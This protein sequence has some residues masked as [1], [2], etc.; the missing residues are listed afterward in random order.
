[1]RYIKVVIGSIVFSLSQISCEST[2]STTER[3]LELT[4]NG[5][6]QPYS[7]SCIDRACC[8]FSEDGVELFCDKDSNN[9][10]QKCNSLDKKCNPEGLPC[11][12]NGGMKTDCVNVAFGDDNEPIYLCL[13]QN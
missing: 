9:T 8:R 12:L 6:Y 3:L 10:C 7:Q 13:A 2:V 11:C 1:M 5:E 4:G